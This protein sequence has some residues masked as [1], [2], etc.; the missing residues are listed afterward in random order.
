MK[1]IP[2]DKIESMTEQRIQEYS[3][4]YG[5][6]DS[7]PVPIDKIIERLFD[8][9][10][11]WDKIQEEDGE[12]ILGG[13]RIRDK[14]VVLNDGRKD[15]FEKHDGLESFT[16]GHELGHWDLF[17]NKD[18]IDNYT[19]DFAKNDSFVMRSTA[20][21]AEKIRVLV[22]NMWENRT[23]YNAIKAIEGKKDDAKTKSIIDRYA[24][25]I[26]MPK[27]LIKMACKDV[28]LTD[29][30][31]LYDLRKLFCVTISALT[32]R[33]QQLKMIYIDKNKKIYKSREEAIGQLTLI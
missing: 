7:P 23:C 3:S 12:I 5:Q 11:L 26:L 31:Y 22:S 32:V 9:N 24:G 8:L 16:K 6:I 17:E 20:D 27:Y 28:D 30:K 13:L 19:F 29:W 14:Q 25:A 10:I 21:N 1:Y 33:L 2:V 4:K 18:L 15:L